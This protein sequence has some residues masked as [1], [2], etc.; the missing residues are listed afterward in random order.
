M[1][2]ESNKAL[3]A[4]AYEGFSRGDLS[5][6]FAALDENI[7]WTHHSDPKSPISGEFRGIAGVQE[8]FTKLDAACEI[9]KFDMH[10]LLAENDTLVAIG[11]GAFTVKATGKSSE[12][13]IVHVF[14]MA[15]DKV[16]SFDEFEQVNPG[17]WD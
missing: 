15:D 7:V 16:I 11:M 5:A 9:T 10:T 13:M 3:V 12:G 2:A 4:A 17:T 8:F 1:S 14:R 6:V